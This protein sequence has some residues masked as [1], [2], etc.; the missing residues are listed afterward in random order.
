MGEGMMIDHISLGLDFDLA[1][2]AKLVQS[3]IDEGMIPK[4]VEIEYH[5]KKTESDND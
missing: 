4:N 1:N 2:E 5:P 3:L